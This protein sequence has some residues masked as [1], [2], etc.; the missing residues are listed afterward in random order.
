MGSW[1]GT[2][3]IDKADATGTYY[4]RAR[5][6]D[7]ATARFTQEDPIGLAGGINEY[8][9]A[10]S[11]PVNLSDPF[12]LCPDPKDPACRFTIAGG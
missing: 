8:G 5:T 2:L 6:Y 4:R 10:A 12:G 7:P 1:N 9:F 11:D 3:L